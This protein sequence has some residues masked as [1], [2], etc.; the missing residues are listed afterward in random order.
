MS[1]ESLT[2]TRAREELHRVALGAFWQELLERARA[3]MAAYPRAAP[4]E[5]PDHDI[6]VIAPIEGGDPVANFLRSRPEVLA[7]LLPPEF[8]V[9]RKSLLGQ[10]SKSAL[11]AT[12]SINLVDGL[13]GSPIG[14]PVDWADLLIRDGAAYL[15]NKAA[16]L[17]Y[18]LAA[19][20]RNEDPWSFKPG[21]TT[22]GIPR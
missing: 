12:P 19:R 7:A 21:T 20:E 4:G 9:V 18:E 11:V 1:D 2:A 16:L 10:L 17:R 15:L 13:T 6:V 5:L 14:G 3:M 22:G 8:A